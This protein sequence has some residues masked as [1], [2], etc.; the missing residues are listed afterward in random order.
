MARFPYYGVLLEHARQ[1]RDVVVVRVR[2]SPD[3]YSAVQAGGGHI[4]GSA[5]VAG[6]RSG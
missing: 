5:A 2:W 4:V 6:E 1:K 3:A